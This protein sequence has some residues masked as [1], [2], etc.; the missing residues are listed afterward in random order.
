[1]SFSVFFE[2]FLMHS[3]W[4]FLRMVNVKA[5]SPRPESRILRFRN[6]AFVSGC[7]WSLINIYEYYENDAKMQ[8]QQNQNKTRKNAEL[9]EIPAK[10]QWNQIKHERERD[11]QQYKRTETKSSR[12]WM[13]VRWECKRKG[14][15]PS[16]YQGNCS[17]P[18]Q[19]LLLVQCE[20]Y[21]R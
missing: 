9:N 13:L 19:L 17:R 21:T 7:S 1:M 12:E 5:L 10:A 15:R 6:S 11:R 16:R 20:N 8:K 2:F 4:L 3:I 18:H 14:G